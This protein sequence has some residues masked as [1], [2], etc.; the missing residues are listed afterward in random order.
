MTAADQLKL[1]VTI[2]LELLG[3]GDQRGATETLLDALEDEPEGERRFTCEC[4]QRF[5]FPGQLDGHRYAAGHFEELI[6]A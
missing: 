2:A 5:R 3:D 4:G 1:R 6:A